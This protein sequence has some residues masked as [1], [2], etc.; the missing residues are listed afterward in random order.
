MGDEKT[1]TKSID[2]EV[3][4]KHVNLLVQRHS[5]EIQSC[6]SVVSSALSGTE[7]AQSD[8][9]ESL[10]TAAR[11]YDAERLDAAAGCEFVDDRIRL[12]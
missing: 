9:P 2:A 7:D 3:T 4:V 6:E 10:V 12:E 5:N 8:A 1:M 11:D